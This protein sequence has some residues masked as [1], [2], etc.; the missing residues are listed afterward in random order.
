[1]VEDRELKRIILEMLEET[2]KDNLKR[3]DHKANEK[4]PEQRKKDAR[5]KEKDKKQT[6]IVQEIKRQYWKQ[7]GRKKH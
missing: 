5:R 4:E 2:G 6:A 3:Q 1:M 7:R